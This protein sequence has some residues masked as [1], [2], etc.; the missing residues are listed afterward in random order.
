M[1]E[2]PGRLINV[3]VITT[4]GIYTPSPGVKSI[5]VE[6][7]GGGGASG[8]LT[9]TGVNENAVS[10]AGSNGAYAK[11]R[12][13]SGFSSISVTIGMG[14]T[15]MGG[16]SGNG[17]DGGT[18]LFG[19]LLSCPGGKGS[20]AGTAKTPPFNEGAAQPSAVPSGSG[21]LIS[22][23]GPYSP[24]PTVIALGMGSN[25]ANSI[26]SPLG[27]FGLGGDGVANNVSAAA[28]NGQAG[29]SGCVIVW[30]YA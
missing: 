28:Q 22:S 14:G 19:T 9:A 21:I 27:G 23:K 6:A 13:T 2:I 29:A 5:I 18:T 24:W 1:E 12:Y 16:G 15:I 26:T 11:A 20:R 17:G 10:A 25:F 8:N 7:I 30:E 4:S 3:R